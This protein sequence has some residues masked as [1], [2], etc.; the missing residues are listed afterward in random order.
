MRGTAELFEVTICDLK[1]GGADR[2]K[3]EIFN[4]YNT[5]DS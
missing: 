4:G 5:G 2:E 1:E 3:T